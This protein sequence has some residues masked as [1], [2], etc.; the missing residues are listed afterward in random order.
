MTP[1]SAFAMTPSSAFAMTPS[2]AFA[3]TPSSAFAMTPSS[4]ESQTE[5]GDTRTDLGEL[6][7]NYRM[8]PLTIKKKNNDSTNT[9]AFNTFLKT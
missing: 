8:S 5:D 9:E 4:P 3:M 7:A 6:E 1:G 2:S